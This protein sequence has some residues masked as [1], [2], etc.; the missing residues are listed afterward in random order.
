MQARKG[1]G[2]KEERAYLGL[3]LGLEVL[4]GGLELL[5]V[6]NHLVDLVGGE[7]SDRAKRTRELISLCKP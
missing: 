7:S 2:Q 1:R 4:V 5:S 6:L 3:V